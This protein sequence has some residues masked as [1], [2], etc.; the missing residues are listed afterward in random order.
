M[1]T[2]ETQNTPRRI[3][4]KPRKPRKPEAKMLR[5]EMTQRDLTRGELADKVGCGPKTITN[6]LSGE[7]RY[8]RIQARIEEVLGVRIWNL[9]PESAVKPKKLL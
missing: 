1:H 7:F 5:H 3:G 6:I 4:I 2:L 8:P 9:I